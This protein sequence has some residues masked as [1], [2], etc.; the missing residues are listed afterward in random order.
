MSVSSCVIVHVYFFN[1]YAF[2]L[3]TSNMVVVVECECERRTECVVC[4]G[5][6]MDVRMQKVNLK[7]ESISYGISSYFHSTVS[8]WRPLLSTKAKVMT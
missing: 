3:L 4:H 1:L 6:A 2:I 7:R 5:S 8:D